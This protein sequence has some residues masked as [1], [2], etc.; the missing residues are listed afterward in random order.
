MKNHIINN[1]FLFFYKFLK[2]T[3]N[4]NTKK[5]IFTNINSINNLQLNISAVKN[6][7]NHCI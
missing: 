7:R 1:K 6:N 2:I 5:K 3:K 4:K